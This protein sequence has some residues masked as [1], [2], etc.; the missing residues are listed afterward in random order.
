MTDE[1]LL[2]R[3]IE[4]A[5]PRVGARALAARM[6]DRH[7]SL[8]PV[9]ESLPQDVA[10]VYGLGDAASRLLHVVPELARY[11]S[12]EAAK[13]FDD[14]S[15]FQLAG[16]YLKGLYIG[17][18]NE[19]FYLMSL[20]KEGKLLGSSLVQ[21]GI[22]DEAPFYLRRVLDTAIRSGAYAVV[23]SHNH[24]SGTPYPSL[25]DVNCTMRSIE[26]LA[27]MDIIV[28]DHVLIADGTP[29]SIRSSGAMPDVLFTRQRKADP[30]LRNWYGSKEDDD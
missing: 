20:D 21:Q 14:V 11:V 1:A 19:C 5:A 3:L 26:A 23:L 27:P 24:P 17:M 15:T 4:Y 25:G 12:R 10:R 16:A 7:G 13:D 9:L 29:F 30:L 28:L 6:L 18:H 2:A 22:V 8:A